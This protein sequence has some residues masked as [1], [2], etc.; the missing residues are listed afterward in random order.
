MAWDDEFDGSDEFS[1]D[2]EFDFD[3]DS[4]EVIPCPNCGVEI[5]E[6]SE[7]CPACGLYVVASVNPWQGRPTW[8]I[9]LGLM[10]IIAVVLVL[11]SL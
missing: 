2:G 4:A 3:D 11:T 8:W 7:Q 10:G 6:E 5:Y 1:D 9:L